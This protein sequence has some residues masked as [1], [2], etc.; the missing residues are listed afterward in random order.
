MYLSNSDPC[1]H[2]VCVCMYKHVYIW[3]DLYIYTC[4]HIVCTYIAQIHVYILYVSVC[5]HIY[6][7]Y[8]VYIYTCIHIVCVCM[9]THIYILSDVYIY[10]CIHIVF[11]CMCT[12]TCVR[13]YTQAHTCMRS[14]MFPYKHTTHR[15]IPTHINTIIHTYFVCMIHILYV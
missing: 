1:I 11:T 6:I 3:Y 2:I 13:T 9:Y 8:D 5:I 15:H 12:H 7:W 14:H 4:I 10:T